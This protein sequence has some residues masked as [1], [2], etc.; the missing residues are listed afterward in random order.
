MIPNDSS[1]MRACCC[2]HYTPHLPTIADTSPWR[3]GPQCG[4]GVR[5]TPS[6][7]D[8]YYDVLELLEHLDVYEFFESFKV[9]DCYKP[10]KALI[11]IRRQYEEQI[12]RETY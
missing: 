5:R 4:V 10:Q 2:Y 11:V 7:P 1:K 8:V 3:V 6:N 12:L 9:C